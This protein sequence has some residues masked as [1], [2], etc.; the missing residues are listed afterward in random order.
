LAAGYLPLGFV[1]VLLTASR[2][3]FL[4]AMV[5]LAGSGLLLVH[6]HPKRLLAGVMALP[7][8]AAILWIA[9]PRGTLER[10]ATI[11]EQLQRG[12]LNQRMN[13]WQAGWHAFVRAPFFGTGAGSF[14]SAAGLAPIDTAHNT[15]LSI[16]VTGGLVA[17]FIATVIVASAIWS[18]LQTQAPL[19]WALA[20]A[21]S[22]WG[23][24]S[25][26]AT[27]EESRTTWLLLALIALAGRLA[28]EEP[29]ELSACFPLAGEPPKHI[30][31]ELE[32]KN[33]Q[34]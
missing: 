14:V 22:V 12:D 29:E 11:S 10:L 23:L 19:K 1:A 15:M 7:P 21:L 26:A 13:I 16:A 2:G 33:A 25:L 5:A 20:A 32:W 4:A 28:D 9:V 30:V 3:G 6:G 31:H 27:V 34:L 24:T 8:I 18:I 17:L